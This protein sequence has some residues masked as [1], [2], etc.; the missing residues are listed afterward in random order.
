MFLSLDQQARLRAA[1]SGWYGDNRKRHTAQSEKETSEKINKV[2]AQLHAENPNAFLD[3][4]VEQKDGSV[5]Y[6]DINARVR[7][8]EFYNEPKTLHISM[9]RG[10]VVP[11]KHKL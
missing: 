1:S 8:R 7:Q 5:S 6:T 3:T 10:F 11:C 4:A 9:Y 2:L